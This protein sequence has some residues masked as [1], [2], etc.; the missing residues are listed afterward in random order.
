MNE[1]TH[2]KSTWEAKVFPTCLEAI[3]AGEGE[4]PPA[5]GPVLI[6][7]CP[8]ENQN[9]IVSYGL[10]TGAGS[11]VAIYQAFTAPKDFIPKSFKASLA[12]LG[13]VTGNLMLWLYNTTGA[14][15]T[16]VPIPGSGR[17]SL[18]FDTA[19]IT[20]DPDGALCEFKFAEA[21]PFVLNAGQ[22]YAVA[23]EN[24]GTLS[25]PSPN[26]VQVG[27]NFEF[28]KMGAAHYGNGGF[29]QA[30]SWM[31]DDA[32]DMIFYIYGEEP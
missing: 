6:D 21:A 2:V 11:I 25:C 9:D 30:G 20:D 18:L 12:K 8:I 16:V 26:R 23:I 17:P 4:P 31:A 7:S 27:F 14:Y 5:E 24:H 19:N 1:V 29:H 13:T 3:A 10:Y 15:P 32:A 22:I 28:G